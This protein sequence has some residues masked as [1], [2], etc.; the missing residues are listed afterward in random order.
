MRRISSILGK[1]A[2]QK[3]VV[4][5]ETYEQVQ[6]KIIYYSICRPIMVYKSFFVQVARLWFTN[7]IFMTL[8]H[9]EYK[10]MLPMFY[11]HHILIT[12]RLQRGL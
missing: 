8:I 12:F 11:D 10:V 4:E 5:K 1:D 3:E 2:K 7:H 9:L 6:C